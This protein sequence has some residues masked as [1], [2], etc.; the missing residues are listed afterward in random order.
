MILYSKNLLMAQ[1]NEDA[2]KILPVEW[3]KLKS[4]GVS[5]GP[6]DE[7]GT[8]T[9][10]K[11]FC[12]VTDKG[13]FAVSCKYSSIVPTKEEILSAFFVEG[14]FDDR[15]NGAF[16]TTNVNSATSNL[17]IKQWCPAIYENWYTSN[18][19]VSR[20]VWFYNDKVVRN[21]TANTLMFWGWKSE[22]LYMG[23]NYTYKIINNKMLIYYLGNLVLT[24]Y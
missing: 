5:V 22:Y 15:Y 10:K 11:D 20:I 17:P 4:F 21:V 12:F 23:N 14:S 7:K 9:P 3:G 24:L 2:D 6:D 18:S 16:Y 13:A 19:K 1:E 8:D